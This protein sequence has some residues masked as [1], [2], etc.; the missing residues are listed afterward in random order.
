LSFALTIR[1]RRSERSLER[2]VGLVGRRGHE[3]E[4]LRLV[5][6]SEGDAFDV[7]ITL[8]S[9]RPPEVLAR[10]IGRLYDVVSVSVD[11]RERNQ[12]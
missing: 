5:P 3:L 2:L 6:A 8:S 10:Q 1:L 7:S 11:E 9:E 12:T 4:S